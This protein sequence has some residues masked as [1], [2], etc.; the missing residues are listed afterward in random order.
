MS[1]CSAAG[2]SGRPG[3]RMVSP[4]L[5]TTEPA[6]A[7]EFRERY[8]PT[9]TFPW[10]R[11]TMPVGV[12]QMATEVW[13]VRV[14]PCCAQLR[15]FIVRYLWALLQSKTRATRKISTNYYI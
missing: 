6:F 8:R 11:M 3:M 4:Q 9:Y 5:R 13:R 15:T 14:R 1:M 10:Q 12:L 2:T 7:S